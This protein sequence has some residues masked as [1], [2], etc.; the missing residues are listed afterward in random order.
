MKISDSIKGF[1][2]LGVISVFFYLLIHCL[3][4]EYNII[5]TYYRIEFGSGRVY[6]ADSVHVVSQREVSFVDA[7]SKRNVTIRGQFVISTPIK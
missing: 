3:I 4:S 6:W 7:Y 2:G 5:T 1:L